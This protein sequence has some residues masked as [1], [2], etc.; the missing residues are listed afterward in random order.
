VGP[1]G[2]SLV[3]GA[4]ASGRPVCPKR[5]DSSRRSDGSRREE[6]IRIRR[7]VIVKYGSTTAYRCIT[8]ESDSVYGDALD[9]GSETRCTN[10]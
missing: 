5:V 3:Q 2:S 1:L 8:G 7:V 10:R 6:G 9:D 4:N